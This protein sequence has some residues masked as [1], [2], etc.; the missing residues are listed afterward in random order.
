METLPQQFLNTVALRPYVFVFL[1]VY[2]IGCSMHLGLK[3]ALLFG[4]A[5]YLITWAS[6]FCSIHTGI[7]YGYYYYIEHTKGYELW[8]LGVPFMDSLSYVFLTYASYS[9]ALFTVSPMICSRGM[10]YLLETKALRYSF[11]TTILG[12]VYL[13]YLDIIIDPVAL[14]GSRWFLGQIYGYPFGGVYFGVPINNFIGWAVV[15]FILVLL[16]QKIDANLARRETRDYTA[17]NSGLRHMI[18]AGLYVG[19][20]AFNIVMTFFIGEYNIGWADIFIVALPFFL[21]WAITHVKNTLADT[22]ACLDAHIRDFPA[23]SALA[24]DIAGT[25]SIRRGT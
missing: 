5:G 10:I 2:L 17:F 14:R 18:G 6:E 13:V 20:V 23:S 7:P 8:V 12:A 21:L 15:G 9:M 1:A 19:I 25:A 24:R 4:A 22:E 16:L 3:R 11:F